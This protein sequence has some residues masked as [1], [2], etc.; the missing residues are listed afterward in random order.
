MC[1]ALED[2]DVVRVVTVMASAVQ[3]AWEIAESLQH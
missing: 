1:L 3:H 2:L